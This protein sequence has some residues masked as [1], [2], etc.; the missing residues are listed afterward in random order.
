M[1]KS[2]FF[3]LS[4]FFVSSVCAQ[5]PPNINVTNLNFKYKHR[6]MPLEPQDPLFFN[7]GVKAVMT[8]TAKIVYTEEQAREM[9]RIVGQNKVENPAEDG[10]LLTHTIGNLLLGAGEVTP[11]KTTLYVKY[12][13]DSSI[14]MTRG[15]QTLFT[16][17]IYSAENE[18][19]RSPQSFKSE[20]DARAYWANNKEI[21]RNE[22]Y[23]FMIEQSAARVNETASK[24]CG[25]WIAAASEQLKQMNSPKHSENGAVNTHTAALADKLKKLDGVTP[26]AEADLAD[27]IAYFKA[28]LERFASDSKSDSK[29]RYIAC[30]NLCVAYLLLDQPKEAIVYADKLVANDQF[31]RDGEKFGKEALKLSALFANSFFKTRQFDPQPYLDELP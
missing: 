25:F 21:I 7:Y 18:Q 23:K 28:I 20:A 12:T 24:K 10:Y 31:P 29:L 5:N 30:H 8:P 15:D 16:Y 27:E 17:K 4:L 2:L 9:L 13:F 14:K 6:L 1:K 26:L 11:G 22:L 19:S 3:A